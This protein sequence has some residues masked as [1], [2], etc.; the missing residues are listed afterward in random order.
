MTARSVVLALLLGVASLS[1][2]DPLA[3]LAAAPPITP[4]REIGIS[5]SGSLSAGLTGA[6]GTFQ[7]VLRV[8]RYFERAH[9]LF[10]QGLLSGTVTDAEGTVVKTVT[11]QPATVPLTGLP[12]ACQFV[13]VTASLGC[14][15]V[16]LPYNPP[17][18]G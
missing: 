3:A 16:S 5:V 17:P 12:P 18:G 9:R 14:G 8:Q 1:V 11:D 13:A 15:Q 2:L 10:A 7:G 6:T 4:P